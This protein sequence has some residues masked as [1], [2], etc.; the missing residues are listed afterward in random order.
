[1]ANPKS[2]FE[3][4]AWQKIWFLFA[5]PLFNFITALVLFIIVP[6]TGAAFTRFDVTI[7]DVYPDSEAALKALR[8]GDLVTHVNGQPFDN[9][10]ELESLLQDYLAENPGSQVTFTISR[11]L[12]GQ[13]F[14]TAMTPVEQEEDIPLER[15]RILEVQSDSPALEAGLLANDIIISANGQEINTLEQMQEITAANDGQ[16]IMVVVEREKERIEVP[17]TPRR[18]GDEDQARIGITINFVV[19][20]P[21]FG[22]VV[23][24][25]ADS[26]E[27][28]TERLGLIDSLD[29]GVTKFTTAME[30]IVRFPAE[31]VRGNLSAQEARPIGPVGVTQVSVEIAQERPYQDFIDWIA[32]ISIALAVTNLLPIP[33]LDGGR[34]LFVLVEIIRGK[35]MEPERE[36]VVHLMGFLFLLMIGIAVFA[37]DI[38]Y[39]IQ[40]QLP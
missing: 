28:Y 22:F 8:E 29:Y 14:D 32:L 7:T 12:T 16:E 2:V 30:L 3:A 23:D 37:L 24:D 15:V 26:R 1:L 13:T 38:I 10:A 31:L 18:L 4:K 27:F 21:A 40:D 33:G 34:I 35:P 5:G 20:S 6:L 17:V 39:P 36:G 19:F 25:D 11:P 9:A